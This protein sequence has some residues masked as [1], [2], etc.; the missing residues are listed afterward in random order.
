MG[1]RAH[2]VYGIISFVLLILV[3]IGFSYCGHYKR[4]SENL[5]DN[6]KI[7]TEENETLISQANSLKTDLEKTSGELK[8]R[9][10]QAESLESALSS[11]R[12]QI[13]SVPS[14]KTGANEQKTNE[15]K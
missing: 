11:L 5:A 14:E 13:R 8:A 12:R 4:K 9:T 7:R 10:Q 1:K 3:V 2:L 6:L 15:Q